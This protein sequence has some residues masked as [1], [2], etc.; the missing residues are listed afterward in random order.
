M[1]LSTSEDSIE[2]QIDS[3]LSIRN[4]SLATGNASM[5]KNGPAPLQ[6]HRRAGW[7]HVTSCARVF[8]TPP[9]E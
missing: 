6:Q 2:E 5:V 1:A 8:F 4:F 3:Q 9:T 7:D